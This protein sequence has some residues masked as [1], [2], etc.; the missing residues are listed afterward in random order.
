MCFFLLGGLGF[1]VWGG[2]DVVQDLG[3]EV[4]LDRIP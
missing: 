2:W 4:S 3:C 1:G